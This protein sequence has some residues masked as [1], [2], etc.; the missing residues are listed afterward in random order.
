MNVGPIIPDFQTIDRSI[1]TFLKDIPHNFLVYLKENFEQHLP[2]IMGGTFKLES[3]LVIDSSSVISSLISFARKGE[4]ILHKI[5]KEPFLR[6]YAPSALEMEVE[7]N[8]IKVSKKM[9]L[10][11][12]LLMKTWRQEIL[13]RITVL[14]PIEFKALF[15]GF[16]TVG[17]RD[18]TDVPFVALHFQL[19]THG[20][21]TKDKD[22]IEQP[23]VRTWRVRGVESLVTVYKKGAF[24][25][26]IFSKVLPNIFYAICEIGVAILRI[27]LEILS[28][29]IQFFSNLAKS[30][31]EAL[32]RLPDWAKILGIVLAGIGTAILI[33]NDEAREMAAALLKK[34]GET[35]AKFA[36][37][38]YNT[39]GTLL[40]KLAPIIGMT[41]TTLTCLFN[42]YQKALEHLHT[43]HMHYQYTT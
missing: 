6:L 18:M 12:E 31:I 32:S 26:F 7:K 19:G 13:P 5:I 1:E 11:K 41:L 40:E 20:I 2:I 27:V 15:R 17:E 33:L 22:I 4:S 34:V 24:S 35:L 9:K 38:V 37:E 30:G 10:S 16:S 29:I 8:M 21:I 39:I 43:L 25:F 14:D 36:S 23:I 3:R 28:K 42:S